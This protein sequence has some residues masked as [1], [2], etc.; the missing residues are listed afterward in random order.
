MGI[1]SKI[2]AEDLYQPRPS[3]GGH[4]DFTIQTDEDYELWK[5]AKVYIETSDNIEN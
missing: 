4:V 3:E 5:F 1:L 2:R